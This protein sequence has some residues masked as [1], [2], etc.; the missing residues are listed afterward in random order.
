MNENIN[1]LPKKP[2]WQTADKNFYY[3]YKKERDKLKKEMTPAEAEL[4]KHL[5]GRKLGTKFR[6]QHII[7]CYIPDFV[8]LSLK[9]IIEIDG[10]IHLKHKK[11]DEERTRRLEQ[12]G[13]KIIRFKNEEVENDLERV[14][15][16]IRKNVDNLLEI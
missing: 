15:E 16:I 12:L 4:W 10:K 7:A 8:A 6:R 1:D 2:K 9:L 5:Q 13:F 3:L 14:L 11:K